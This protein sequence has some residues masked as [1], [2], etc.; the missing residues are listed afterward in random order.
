MSTAVRSGMFFGTTVR[1]GDRLPV[2]V[3]NKKTG[4]ID[5]KETRRINA[6]NTLFKHAQENNTFSIGKL[7]NAVEKLTSRKVGKGER[8]AV[9]NAAEKVSKA[10]RARLKKRDGFSSGGS[11]K[12][13]AM[14]GGIRKAKTYG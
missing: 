9:I 4:K 14:G 11:V 10:D 2:V 12:K 3:K 13:Y 8:A 7:F 1:V 6:N 5:E